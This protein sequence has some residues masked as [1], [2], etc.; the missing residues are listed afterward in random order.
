M[1]EAIALKTQALRAGTLSGPKV[2]EITQNSSGT[3]E[4]LVEN[5]DT[6][7]KNVEEFDLVVLATGMQ[8]SLV[9]EALPQGVQLD[10]DGFFVSGPGAGITATGCAKLPLDVMRSA[11]SATGTA[12]KAIQTVAGR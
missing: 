12:V 7:L 4:L 5:V 11:Q 9:G 1:I 2:A 10:E 3:V 6:G 8:P